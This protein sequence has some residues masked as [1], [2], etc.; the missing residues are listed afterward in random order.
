MEL[1]EVLH[2]AL[3][4]SGRGGGSITTA[5]AGMQEAV[6]AESLSGIS[7]RGIDQST[8]HLSGGDALLVSSI[9]ESCRLPTGEQQSQFDDLIIDRGHFGNPKTWGRE[10]NRHRT[11]HVH[12]SSG[13][14]AFTGPPDPASM[15]GGAFYFSES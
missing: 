6:V 11:N 4:N 14:E 3:K 10:S 8:E 2:S 9:F 13:R 15:T 5:Q 7:D 12:G 1:V